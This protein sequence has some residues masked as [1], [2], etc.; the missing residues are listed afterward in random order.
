MQSYKQ[1]LKDYKKGILDHAK[2]SK[3]EL[4]IYTKTSCSKI[5]KVMFSSN[6]FYCLGY[7]KLLKKHYVTFQFPKEYYV[8]GGIL[9]V[10]E[11][12]IITEYIE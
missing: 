5:E 11:Q 4:D 2:F 6:G 8:Q 7:D 10:D 9:V 12:D 3:E 1:I